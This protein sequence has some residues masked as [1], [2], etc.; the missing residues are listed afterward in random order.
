MLLSSL[1][2]PH[3]SHLYLRKEEF[4]PG[5]AEPKPNVLFSSLHV[6]NFIA[7]SGLGERY[8][9]NFLYVAD[10]ELSLFALDESFDIAAAR[11]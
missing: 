4:Y 2:S 10:V 7:Q 3:D 5:R 6:S 1:H 11:I 8:N 9:S